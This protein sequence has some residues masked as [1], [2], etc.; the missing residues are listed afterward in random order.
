MFL[1]CRESHQPPILE[2][3][4][5][6]KRGRTLPLTPSSRPT[7]HAQPIEAVARGCFEAPFGTLNIVASASGITGISIGPRPLAA[8][9][10]CTCAKARALIEQAQVQL[11]EYFSRKRTEFSLP[12]DARGTDFQKLAWSALC[13]IPFGSTS[14]YAQVVPQSA[15]SLLPLGIA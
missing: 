1:E 2:M 15:R 5:S 3:V 11:R 14:S 13:R 6:T 10:Q 12:L 7:L 8:A 4:K 9:A